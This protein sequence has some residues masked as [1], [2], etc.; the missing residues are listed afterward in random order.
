[1]NDVALSIKSSHSED[2]CFPFDA[3]LTQEE[4]AS[5][6]KNINS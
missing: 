1:M 4:I 2:F 6:S 3:A 5:Y